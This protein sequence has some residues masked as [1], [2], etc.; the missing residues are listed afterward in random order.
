MPR[1]EQIQTALTACCG[2]TLVASLFGGGEKFAYASA[3][4]GS[5]Y[6]IGSMARSIRD[7]EL[8]VNFLMVLAAV[9]AVIVGRPVEAAGLLFLFSLS[10]TL[11]SFAMA[12]T[13]SA[14]EGLIKLRPS[15][16]TIRIGGED[17]EV[18]IEELKVGDL[19]VIPAFE[20]VPTDAVVESGES[21]ADESAMTGEAAPVSKAPGSKVIGG[22][23]NLEGLLLARVA[24]LS[25]ES[26]LSKIVALVQEAQE[27]KASGEKLSTW[28]GE[29]YTRFVLFAFVASFG[30]VFATHP[31]GAAGYS[32][33]WSYALY[34]SLTLLVA[35]SPC[36]LVIS[37]PATT[38]S[39]LAWAARHGIL[40]RGGRYIELAGQVQGIALD[41]TGTLTAGK[42]ELAEIC[43]CHE[44]PV[45]AGQLACEDEEACWRGTGSLS[46]E[47]A[48]LLEAAA[49][50][51]QYSTHPVAEAIVRAAKEH[52]L[53]V[54]EAESRRTAPG[55]G[56]EA[57]LRGKTIAIG[58]LGW[59]EGERKGPGE[60]F[61]SHVRAMTASGMTT[62][63][64]SVDG[65]FAAL[66]FRDKLRPEAKGFLEGVRNLGVKRIAL[67]TGDHELS[68]KAVA[69]DLAIDEIHAG[70]MPSDKERLLR[71]FGEAGG[72]MM[73]GDGVNDAPS[74][75]AAS[76]GVAMGGLGSDIALNA[77]D[78]VLMRDDLRGVTDLIRLGRRTN[79][80][81]RANL[82]FASSVIV[83]LT[84]W[85][86]AFVLPLPI[87]VI[88]HE[89]STVLVILN[90][91][92]LLS[93]GQAEK[94]RER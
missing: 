46:P 31:S 76:V 42:P 87:A 8:D 37:T 61:V 63:I 53:E 62:A 55:L 36:A 92:R 90:G 29:R 48:E 58:R 68:A 73:I 10:S 70:L 17:R 72:M 67:L 27:N 81:I 32:S 3:A 56:V 33:P 84:L 21:F 50:A 47:A 2:A 19:V 85:S 59:F 22:T 88:G 77:A 28:F 15:K 39:A 41:K 25:E 54:P 60:G 24:A 20:R 1:K 34:K 75:A 13:E 45:L 11:E 44:A 43:V 35:L 51:E 66:G 9:G 38:L 16:A 4:F 12:R 79:A 52:G 23:Q 69:G 18:P 94:K 7:R 49:A 71:K 86:L 78:V 64:L 6:A 91:L 65:H 14:I 74:L 30:I 89:G 5:Y 40:V 57:T 93:F 83:G 26:T 82:I 80:T